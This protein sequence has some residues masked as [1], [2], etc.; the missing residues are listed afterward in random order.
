MTKTAAAEARVFEDAEAL[1]R[2]AAEWLCGL[3]LAGSST[4]PAFLPSSRMRDNT[5]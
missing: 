5:R 2:N 3:A 4:A 1:A